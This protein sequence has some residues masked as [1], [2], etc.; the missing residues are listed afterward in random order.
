MSDQQ[1]SGLGS[2]QEMM[3]SFATEI[4]QIE[5]AESSARTA[6]DY[7]TVL[8]RIAPVHRTAV[9][10][11][12]V[13]QEARK[14]VSEDADLI[15]LRDTAYDNSR[16]VDLLYHGAKNSL[17]CAVARNAESLA[18]ASHD[19]ASAAHRLNLLAA[20]FFPL[21]TLAAILG[22]N[23]QHGFE[24]SP[25][26]WAFILFVALGLFGG[27]VLSAVLFRRNVVDRPK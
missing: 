9:H 8:D 4:D 27:A 13:L 20:F 14:T 7:F 3:E 24:D 18:R 19:M 21:L 12:E 16:R 26:P 17:D 2:F 25:P 15:N 5:H 10:M 6:D 22:V 1:G 23:L 11:Y